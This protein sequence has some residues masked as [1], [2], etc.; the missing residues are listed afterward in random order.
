MHYLLRATGK[1]EMQK[2]QHRHCNQNE[3][4]VYSPSRLLSVGVEVP[5]AAPH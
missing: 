2:R 4:G 5:S 3:F 1:L